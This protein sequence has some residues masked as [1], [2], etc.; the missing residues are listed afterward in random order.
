MGG[1]LSVPQ[2]EQ[3]GVHYLKDIYNDF[4]LLSFT[5]I[6]D[7]FDL[8]GSNFFFYL[9][10]RSALRA[11]GNILCL[12]THSEIYSLN[13]TELRVWYPNCTI[14]LQATDLVSLQ[15]SDLTDNT[16][17]VTIC[18]LIL[19]NLSIL[20]ISKLKKRVIFAGL[21]AAKKMVATGWKPPH[22]LTTQSWILSLLDVIYMELSTARING[23]NESTLNTWRSTADSLKNML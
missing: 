20:N 2:W 8:P 9:Q 22:S 15:L 6:K 14:F 4:G 3:R 7:A 5:D 18:V 19:N 1:D 10:L 21:T 17:P 23:A 13:K 16:V 12:P 11:H